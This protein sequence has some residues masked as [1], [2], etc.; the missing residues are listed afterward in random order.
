MGVKRACAPVSF[1]N[2]TRPPT[3]PSQPSP[4]PRAGLRASSVFPPVTGAEPRP[5]GERIKSQGQQHPRQGAGTSLP[6][7][8]AVCGHRLAPARVTPDRWAACYLL[9]SVLRW[10]GGGEGAWSEHPH[11]R[12]REDQPP[13]RPGVGEKGEGCWWRS[14]GMQGSWASMTLAEVS[15]PPCPL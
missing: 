13:A 15:G 3:T 11:S 1:I 9:D 2:S 4:H 10:L 12:G 5:G 7:C 6:A 14:A 8:P